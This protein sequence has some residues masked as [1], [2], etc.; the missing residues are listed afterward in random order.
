MSEEKIKAGDVVCLQSDKETNSRQKF[1]VGAAATGSVYNIHWYVAGELKT[2][3]V[4]EKALHK[5]E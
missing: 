5:D 3:K 1:T 4:H 2:A